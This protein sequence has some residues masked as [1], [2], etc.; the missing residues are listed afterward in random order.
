MTTAV[1]PAKTERPMEWTQ[2]KINLIKKTVAY[3]T[4]DLELQLFLHTAERTGLDPLRRQLHAIKREDKRGGKTMTIQTGID[5]YRLIAART[6]EHGG[7][8][9]AVHDGTVTVSSLCLKCGSEAGGEAPAKASVT[10]YRIK[11]GIRCPFSATARWR[12]YYPGDGPAGFFWR[13]MPFGQLAKCAEA[14]ALRKAFPAEMSGLYT[15]DEMAQAGN[16][17]T[18]PIEV[19]PA[20]ATS[21]PPPPPIQSTPV[22]HDADDDLGD[23]V[24][25]VTGILT[26]YTPAQGS[27]KGSKPQVVEIEMATGEVL[28]LGGFDLLKEVENLVGSRVDCSYISKPSKRGGRPFLN[29]VAIR[30]ASRDSILAEPEYDEPD[31]DFDLG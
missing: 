8:D 25:C 1:M 9:D 7:T 12:E 2:E 17:E 30:P 5:G 31:E 26:R 10:V 27:G 14:L 15:D 16:P 19:E 6:G 3:G 28:R 21:P 23:G 20:T 4:T 24:E 22:I 11:Q 29:V 18:P 13:K